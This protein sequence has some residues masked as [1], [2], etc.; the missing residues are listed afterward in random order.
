MSNNFCGNSD[1]IKFIVVEPIQSISGDTYVTGFTYSNSN[2]TIFQNQGQLPLSVNLP[3]YNGNSWHIPSGTTVTVTSGFQY[4]VYGN[5]YI[6]G[7]LDLQ[8]DSQ[9]VVLNGNLILS[10]AGTIIGAGTSYVISL[11]DI[12]IS[13]VT[14]NND[15][16]SITETNGNVFTVIIPTFSGNTSGSCITDLYVQNLNSCSPLHIQPINNGDVYISESGGNV[17]IGT[18]SPSETL[19]VN[20]IIKTKGLQVAGGNV[21]LLNL[22]SDVGAS[23]YLTIDSQTGGVMIKTIPSPPTTYGLFAQINTVNIGSQPESSLIGNGVGSLSIPKNGFLVGDSFN[24]IIGGIISN[25]VGQ[26]VTIR[27]KSLTGGTG[28][29]V[30]AEFTSSNIGVSNKEVWQL[31]FNFTIRKV[32]GMGDAEIIT[33]GTFR[34]DHGASLEEVFAFKNINNTTF[35]TTIINELEITFEWGNPQA[36]PPLNI[37]SEIFILNKIF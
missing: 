4:F 5:M 28:S 8:L 3:I 15:I 19:D 12:H 34:I 2:L 11:P 20:G 24:G 9:L 35:D 25:G 6:D 18:S 36:P 26:S 16:L 33:L 37:S 27:I 32:G 29:M 22:P 23:D 14:Y 17:G 1:L 31:S 30:L 21:Q 10:G 7:T 13:G